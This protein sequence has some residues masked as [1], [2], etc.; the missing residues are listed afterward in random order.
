[1]IA[2]PSIAHPADTESTWTEAPEQGNVTNRRNGE[3]EGTRGGW[4]S[5]EHPVDVV[6]TGTTEQVAGDVL[7][8]VLLDPTWSRQ[9]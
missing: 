1:M 8:A 2:L 5:R 9:R 6:T 3:G 7:D 4:R